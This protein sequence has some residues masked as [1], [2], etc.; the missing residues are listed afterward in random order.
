MAQ[1]NARNK[2]DSIRVLEDFF[3]LG[4][5]IKKACEYAG[6]PYTTVHTWILNDE[7]LRMQVTAWQ[8]ELG[9]RS[10]RNWAKSIQKGSLRSSQEWLSKKE[11]DEFSERKELTGANGEQLFDDEHR[12]K[13]DK[14]IDELLEGDAGEAGLEGA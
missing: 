5:S 2:E 7:A 10:R 14:L 11:K 8:N 4:C 13:A 9:V 3:K 6:I 1:G 12:E